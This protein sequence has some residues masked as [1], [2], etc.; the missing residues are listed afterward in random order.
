MQ[1][2]KEDATAAQTSYIGAM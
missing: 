2:S 1:A